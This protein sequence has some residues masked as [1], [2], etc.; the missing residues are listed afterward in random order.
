MQRFSAGPPPSRSP[1]LDGSPGSADKY[2]DLMDGGA[3]EGGS[4]LCES[5]F[6][7]VYHQGSCDKFP[8]P[9]IM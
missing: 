5:A 7:L 4:L 9:I 3:M 2:C 1:Y 8:L 6:T